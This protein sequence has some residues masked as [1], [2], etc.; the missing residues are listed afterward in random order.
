ML[1]AEDALGVVRVTERTEALEFV[2][3]Y[4][5]RRRR[6]KLAPVSADTERPESVLY[7]GD[8]VRCFCQQRRVRVERPVRKSTSASGARGHDSAV[9][10]TRL[11]NNLI[12]AQ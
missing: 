7:R 6:R 10:Q 8:G 9:A 5:V 11:D 1:V 2:C 3:F 12:S 4:S